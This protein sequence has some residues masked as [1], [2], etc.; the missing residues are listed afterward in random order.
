MSGEKKIFFIPVGINYCPILMGTN[1][2]WQQKL[3]QDFMGDPTVPS[4]T[5]AA[6]SRQGG[7]QTSKQAGRQA[8]RQAGKAC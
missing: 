2:R 6:G 1:I 3:L 7:R 5:Q 8:G 4:Y